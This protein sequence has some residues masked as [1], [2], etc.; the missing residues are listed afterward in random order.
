MLTLDG[1]TIEGHGEAESIVRLVDGRLGE[2]ESGV[3]VDCDG[4]DP[5]SPGAVRFLQLL[6]ERERSRSWAWYCTAPVE[7]R[8]L[9]RACSDAGIGAPIH[10]SF[11]EAAETARNTRVATITG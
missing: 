11:H 8:K 1:L 7:R 9:S 5:G 4:F 6:F 10:R 3:V 2:L